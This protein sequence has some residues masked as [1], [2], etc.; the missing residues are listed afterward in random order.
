L[1]DGIARADQSQVWVEIAA[2][3]VRLQARSG[4]AA[5]A[6]MFEVHTPA[7][8]TFV[9]G[10]PVVDGQ[11]GAVFILDGEPL[12]VDLFDCAQ[13]L[14]SLFPKILRGY[15]L[16]AIDRR[17]DDASGGATTTVTSE[18]A[19]TRAQQFMRAVLDAERKPFDAPGLGET[20]R[21]FAPQVSGG[22][23]TADGHT[24]HMSAFRAIT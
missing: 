10:L 5:M 17:F 6:A 8:E 4:T 12:G 3:S 13:T 1:R 7:I 16:D 11:V 19:V 18:Q 15:A 9:R 22:G 2:K 21:L 14:R 20:W 23:L 24:V